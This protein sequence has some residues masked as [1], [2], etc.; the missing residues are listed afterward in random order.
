MAF[1][2]LS[3]QNRLVAVHTDFMRHPTY[4][5]LGG[6]TQ[7]GAVHVSDKVPTAGTDGEDVYYNP[8]FI[9]D[10]SRKQLRYLVGHETMHKALRHCTEYAG[11]KERFP[12]E[13]PLAIDYVVNW[14]LE[15][16][17]TG[18]D[19]FLERP[20]SV[21]PLIDP[22]YAD[23]SLPEVIRELRKPPPPGGGARGTTPMDTHIMQVK[24]VENEKEYLK[25]EERISDAV[26]HGEILQGQMR[27]ATG[28]GQ[29]SLSGFRESTTDWKTPLRRF[30]QE[31]CEGDEQSRFSPPNKRML[32]LDI[33]LPSHFSET[34]G[35][36]IVACDTS[37]SMRPHYAMIFGEIARIVQHATPASIRL[38]WWDT[39]IA[40]EQ[41][42]T[43][44]DYHNIKNAMRPK[45]GGGTTVS[46]VAAYIR[47]QR[48][49][50]KATVMLTDG[51]IE[52]MY[53]VTPGNVLWGI[54]DH[55]SF[56]PLRGK[57]LHITGE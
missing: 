1:K 41:V 31:I 49:K 17:D 33:I 7:I 54:V 56:V 44:K 13:F 52:A 28:A 16:M 46:C 23:M 10:M 20:T 9:G 5:I 43:P 14:Q 34:T 27:S 57:V 53:E 25:L 50:P 45:G 8:D 15:S 37:G 51:L 42:F 40:G 6:V 19:K 4:C 18:A 11:L 36:I 21:P 48:Y 47:A 38:L 24:T 35:E 29:A 3:L 32:P 55:P 2:D 39:A 12:D 22:A 26:R 30:F